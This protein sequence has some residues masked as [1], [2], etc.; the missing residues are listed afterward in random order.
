MH[1]KHVKIIVL[2]MRITAEIWKYIHEQTSYFNSWERKTNF[3]LGY[4][5]YQQK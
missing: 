5:F 2:D 3:Y 4:T 1:K